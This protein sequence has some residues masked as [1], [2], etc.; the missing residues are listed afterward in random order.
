[1]FAGGASMYMTA[2]LGN[3]PY[4]AIAPIIVDRS[5]LPYRAVRVVQDLLFVGLALV[6]GGQIGVGTVMTA[7]FAGPL[8][9]FF[10][11]KVNKPLMRKDLAG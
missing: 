5:R 3:S 4:D 11:E 2:G 6:F 1:L 10:T 8:I 9:D 7:F